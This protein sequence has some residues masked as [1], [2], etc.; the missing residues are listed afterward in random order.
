MFR[1]KVCAALN[2]VKPGQ[3]GQGVCGRCKEALDISGA[4][5]E[6]DE[7]ALA[8]AIAGSAVPV[9]VDFWAPW[10][11]PC[12]VVSPIVDQFARE[13][14]GQ[15]IALK[16][17]T[18]QNPSAASGHDIRGIP[19]FIVFMNGREVARKAGA[20]PKDVFA[21]WAKEVLR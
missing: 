11:G 16:L 3:P 21:A 20:M 13:N 17:N 4:P 9:L 12:R 18:E 6:V 14:A 8:R 2:N 10:C 19:T 15:L 7:A 5:Q 1:C